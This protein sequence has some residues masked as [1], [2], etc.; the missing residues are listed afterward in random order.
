MEEVQGADQRQ[1]KP[2]GYETVRYP[3]SGLVSTEADQQATAEHNKTYDDPVGNIKI[4]NDNVAAWMNG[5]VQLTDDDVHTPM[6]DTYSIFSRF[7]ISLDAPNYIV[8]SNN[9]SAKQWIK[10]QGSADPH[11]VVALESPHNAVHLAVGGFY[12]MG[13]YNA[14]TILGANGDMGDNETAGFDPI[15]F[16]HHA[17]IDYVFWKWQMKNKLTSA[18][19]LQIIPGYAGTIAAEGQPNIQKD[20]HL[21]FNISLWPFQKS[22][23]NL[24]T[25]ADVTDIVNQL[26]YQYGPGSLDP[27]IE[28]RPFL[29]QDKQAPIV[30]FVKSDKIDG[31]QYAGSFVV[32][33]FAKGPGHPEEVG[34]GR[35]PI[36]SRWERPRLRKLPKPPQRSDVCACGY[37]SAW[38]LE[39]RWW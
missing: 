5:T 12:A 29:G 33:T 1:S 9:T 39:G 31:A 37:L 10:D 6:P 19:D 2:Q 32:R 16:L 17:F 23:R 18:G 4:L 24:Y 7:K 20:A 38:R 27:F 28:D 13:N 8:F 30:S 22:D 34:I 35:D 36:L 3:L 14:D 25:G 21:D 26:D 11:Y 15:F